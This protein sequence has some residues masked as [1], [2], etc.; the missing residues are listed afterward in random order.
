ME[1]KQDRPIF[2]EELLDSLA[3]VYVEAVLEQMISC[4]QKAEQEVRLTLV[5]LDQANY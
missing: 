1:A 2:S 4:D 3:L 5:A